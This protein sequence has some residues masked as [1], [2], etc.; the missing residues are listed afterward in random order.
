M[1]REKD[2]EF[3]IIWLNYDPDSIN[4]EMSEKSKESI[5]AHA[6]G[7]YEFIEVKDV[8]GFVHA[9][10]QGLNQAKGKWL[11][12]VANDV[13]IEDPDWLS[14]FKVENALIG[15]RFI[16]FF[17][18]GEERPDFACWGLSKETFEKLGPMDV[19]FAE[20]YGFDD[21]DYVYRARDLGIKL[22]DAQVKLH[23]LECKTYNTVFKD[24]KQDMTERNQR[25]FIE[26]WKI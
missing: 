11:I 18:T 16:T 3:S 8:K 10:N 2:I 24:L 15:W 12:V 20:G 23:H 13:V 7:S 26:K 25:L 1:D 22:H 5:L 6:K 4:V 17:L 21:D 14:K 9:V 19:R